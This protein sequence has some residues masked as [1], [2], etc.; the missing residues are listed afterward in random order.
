[1]RK[2][3]LGVYH[4]NKMTAVRCAVVCFVGNTHARAVVGKAR[5][6]V[7]SSLL[8]IRLLTLASLLCIS[9]VLRDSYPHALA[10]DPGSHAALLHPLHT[11]EAQSKQTQL[12]KCC[13]KRVGSSEQQARQLPGESLL[14]YE[15]AS[16]LRLRHTLRIKAATHAQDEEL[17]VSTAI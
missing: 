12:R 9:L 2:L 1:M 8:C 10:L 3:R 14:V 17:H 13:S 6:R 15:P 5:V 4:R 11:I 16:T 7:V